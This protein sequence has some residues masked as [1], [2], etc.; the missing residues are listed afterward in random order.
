[1]KGKIK[2]NGK[3]YRYWTEYRESDSCYFIHGYIKLFFKETGLLKNIYE[4]TLYDINISYSNNN[5]L[6]DFNKSYPTNK[7]LEDKLREIIDE[8]SK[9]GEIKIKEIIKN[10][11]WK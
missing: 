7:Q 10:I 8:Y 1:M 4:Y 9:D 3:T 11:N 2:H 6:L 5:A